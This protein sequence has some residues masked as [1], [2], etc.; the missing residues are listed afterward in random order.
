MI[1]RTFV[2]SAGTCGDLVSFSEL[3]TA[4]GFQTAIGDS[5]YASRLSVDRP[6][7]QYECLMDLTRLFAMQFDD[8]IS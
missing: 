1:D 3:D 8:G 7:R 4:G 6:A 2:G 5:R